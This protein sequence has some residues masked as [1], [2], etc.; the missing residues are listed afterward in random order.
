MI[1]HHDRAKE[2]GS[3]VGEAFPGNVGRG[4]VDGFKHGGF[5]ADV[6]AADD[7]EAADQAGGEIAH[8]VAVKIGQ[9]QHVE[10]LRIQ[11]NLHASV[12]D[13]EFFVLDFGILRGDVTD[14]LEKEAV[15]ELHDVGFVD[16]VNF[17]AAFALGIFEGEMRDLRGGF[18]SDDFEAFDNAGDDFVFEAGVEI[19][20]VFADE[21]DVDVLETGFDAGK[22]LDRA[23]VG[24][25]I[26]G[27]AQAV[28]DAGGAA[29][30]GRTHRALEGDAIAAH[31][32]NGGFGDEL[33]FFGGFVGAGFNFFPVDFRSC[34]L[35]DAA[36]GGGDFRADAFAGDQRD[37]VSDHGI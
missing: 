6:G 22:I 21:H 10:L 29:G 36:R 5:V 7:A 20:G 26:E 14:A 32:F 4:A 12:I 2:Q 23:N 28:V 37:F 13:D 25:E 30:D 33:A 17:F 24:V 35:E 34:S 16:G 31:G 27:F 19:F 1:E 15:R 8:H 9:Q 18:F 11:N 3:G